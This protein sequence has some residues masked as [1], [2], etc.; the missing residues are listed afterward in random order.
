MPDEITYRRLAEADLPLTTEWLNRPH[1]RRF[2]QPDP[3]SLAEVA[4]KYGPR[5]RGEEPIH[6]SVAMLD[7]APFAFLQCYRNVDW[8]D[9]K[10]TTAVDHGVSI[11]LFIGEPDMI[12]RGL[13]QRMLRQYVEQVALAE[14]PAER[15]CWIGHELEN[16]AAR[17]CSVAAGFDPVREHIEDGKRCI[18]LVCQ[19][20]VV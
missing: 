20:H 19:A 13:G 7:G 5:I 12:G 14:H 18:L 6:S 1:L 11:D 4:A 2:Y 15:L 16:V 17:K 9:H 3:I 8:P 10:A